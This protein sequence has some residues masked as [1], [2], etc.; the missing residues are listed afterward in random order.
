MHL[1]AQDAAGCLWR[2][3]PKSL[4][5]FYLKFKSAEIEFN[6]LT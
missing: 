4:L 2:R 5:T 6:F 3:L 1:D